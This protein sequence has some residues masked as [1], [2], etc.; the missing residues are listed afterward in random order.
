[1]PVLE[2]STGGTYWLAS[3]PKS[4]NTWFRTFLANYQ[5]GEDGPI[6]INALHTG[7][8]A[9][10]RKMID[11]I[12]CLET[13]DLD[14]DEIDRLRPLVHDW[15]DDAREIIYQKTHDAYAIVADGTP[16]LGTQQTRGALYF[17]RN[18]L[19]VAISY[20]HHNGTDID[21]AIERMGRDNH[22]LN[23]SKQS[24]YRQVRQHMGTWSQ[25]VLS[26]VDAP[27]LNLLVVRYEDMHSDPHDQFKRAIT[28]LGLAFDAERFA[29][30]LRFSAFDVVKQQEAISGFVER[31][32]GMD[33]FF[34]KG[35]AGDWRGQLSDAQIARIIADHAPVM[36]RFGYLDAAGNPL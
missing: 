20:A 32:G 19:D 27:A 21:K 26:W 34:R 36:Q 1:M 24:I 12:L 2:T 30:A 28:H 31:P 29:R 9:S 7:G 4:G 15:Q 25:H 33:G 18:P 11:D 10:A 35:K 3:Y 5:C 22:G 6:D 14:P 16:L 13:S 8:I 23:R 17:I